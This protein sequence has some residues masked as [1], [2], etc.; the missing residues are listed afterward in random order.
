MIK[1][2]T[3]KKPYFAL[4][5]SDLNEPELL[6]T[7]YSSYTSDEPVECV[8]GRTAGA[9]NPGNSSVIGNFQWTGAVQGLC[10]LFL[11]TAASTLSPTIEPTISGEGGSLASSLD[12]SVSKGTRWI[13]DMFGW[14]TNG[15][16]IVRFLLKRSNPERKR[17]GPVVISVNHNALPAG[18][19]H[20][21]VGEK[22]IRD[23]ATL[24]RLCEVILGKW[25][26]CSTEN[27]LDSNSQTSEIVS[28]SLTPATAN[29][30]F[31]YLTLPRQIERAYFDGLRARRLDRKF[32]FMTQ[33]ACQTWAEIIEKSE[34]PYYREARTLLESITSK[35]IEKIDRNVNLVA[36]RQ[37]NAVKETY[38]AEQLLARQK[39]A[40]FFVDT[41]DDMLRSALQ[42]SDKL[43]AHRE[44]Y[45]ADFL[46]SDLLAM[47]SD[48]IKAQ[49]H[50]NNLF[51]L[52]GATFGGY[53]Q[54]EVMNPLRRA[55]GSGDYLL[56]GTRVLR[57][58]TI[59]E[60][61][62][63]REEII[64]EHSHAPFLHQAVSSLNVLGVT[65]KDG[66][67]ET[68]CGPDRFLPEALLVEHYFRF[69]QERT[70]EFKGETFYFPKNERI[71]VGEFRSYPFGLLREVLE[72]YGLTVID[73]YQDNNSCVGKFFC[74]A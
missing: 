26:N 8:R 37:G 20:I 11:R 64:K 60:E 14:R 68:E 74:H 22:E 44:V 65:A 39:L 49:H 32:C 40:L 12:Y 5:F 23:C 57:A 24:L 25:D 63:K 46:D 73:A 9:Y 10:L 69:N 62:Q 4:W 56:L 45:Y 38:F 48:G 7:R 28:T 36:I 30:R 42:Y 13:T 17:K 18:S 66:A 43:N 41:S 1:V 33:S 15:D 34:Y 67:I 58:K 59:A 55:M 70:L 27:K 53:F 72:A 3:M 21:F 47:I 31:N 52:L 71:L 2:A 29:P 51:L 19:I 6:R 50:K 61:L 54:A 16:P 35:I